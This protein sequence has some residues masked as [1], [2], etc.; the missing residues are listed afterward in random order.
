MKNSLASSAP[1]AATDAAAN[2][3]ASGTRDYDYL[4]LTAAITRPDLH[5]AV[6]P[7]YLRGIGT[8]RVKWLIHVDAVGTQASVQQ[9]IDHLARLLRAPN[10]DLEFLRVDGPGCFFQATRRLALRAGGLLPRCRTGV[11]WLEDDW[12]RMRPSP[13]VRALQALRGVLARARSARRVLRCAGRLSEQQARLDLETRQGNPRWFVSLVARDRVSFNPGIWSPALFEEAVLRPLAS[14]PS[15]R[16]DDP[17][18]L[19]ADPCNRAAMARRLS[20]F[21]E[22]TYRDAGRG[23]S[24]RQGLIKWN[25]EPDALCGRGAV[26]YAPTRAP[27]SCESAA[28][29]P[30]F[31]AV[32]RAFG[33]RLPLLLRVAPEQGRLTGRIVGFP[34]ARFEAHAGADGAAELYL[35]RP[36]GW[37]YTFPFRRLERSRLQVPAPELLQVRLGRGLIEA[38][39]LRNWPW[40]RLLLQV[41]VQAVLG[42]AYY[43]VT[44]ARRLLRFDASRQPG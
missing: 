5:A 42:A 2:G 27:A 30:G 21:V 11:V 12:L 17:E 36:H 34:A 35:W 39:R 26:T 6:F 7:G 10:V 13:G 25:K 9:T 41:P 8:A 18:T 37:S 31:W 23:W 14:L 1:A 22:P 28:L 44:L 24:A 32:R 29:Q 4:I 20:L 33:W 19:C 38:R 15:D 3:A 16:V 40:I 43:G